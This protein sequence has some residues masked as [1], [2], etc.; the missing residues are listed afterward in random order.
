MLEL[1]GHAVP[2][3]RVFEG[4]FGATDTL[5]A[6]GKFGIEGDELHLILRHVFFGKNRIGRALGNTNGTID[7]LIRINDE[8]VGSFSKTVDRTH[9]HTVRE[10]TFNTIFRH[11]MRHVFHQNA[12]KMVIFYPNRSRVFGIPL[13]CEVA[14][15]MFKKM[16]K[17]SP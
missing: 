10:L 8:K 15:L 2:V 9:V 17:K 16:P 5:E 3:V 4:F 1:V 6:R 11:D 14:V 7:A 12:N 13:G